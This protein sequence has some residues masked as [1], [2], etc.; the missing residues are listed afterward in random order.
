MARAETLLF[1]DRN[2]IEDWWY[3]DE[4]ADGS[5]TLATK[6]NDPG[7]VPLYLIC[8]NNSYSILFQQPVPPTKDSSG[9]PV[10]QYQISVDDY[11]G[12]AIRWPQVVASVREEAWH[13]RQESWLRSRDSGL[14]AISIG[15]SRSMRYEGCSHGGPLNW[16]SQSGAGATMATMVGGRGGGARKVSVA[17]RLSWLGV[18]H[19]GGVGYTIFAR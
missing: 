13:N 7:Q 12:S 2:A 8:K 11:P 14:R 6:S 3:T 16:H 4:N 10:Y 5:L 9:R 17:V 18:H 15:M 19:C 1:S